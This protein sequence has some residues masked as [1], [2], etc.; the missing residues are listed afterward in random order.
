MLVGRGTAAL[1]RIR[2]C[3]A[4][5]T[6]QE[7]ET[8]LQ[9]HFDAALHICCRVCLSRPYPVFLT[10]IRCLPDVMTGA[11]SPWKKHQKAHTTAGARHPATPQGTEPLSEQ[12]HATGSGDEEFKDLDAEIEQ[13]I[14]NQD[15]LDAGSALPAGASAGPQGGERPLTVDVALQA[16]PNAPQKKVKKSPLCDF[17]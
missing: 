10:S 6:Q 12:S 11:S 16:A 9:V 8:G 5:R 1:F 7:A 17:F 2:G 3:A 14:N 13:M 15:M 4:G